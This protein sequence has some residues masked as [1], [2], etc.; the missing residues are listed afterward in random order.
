MGGTSSSFDASSTL[1]S[2]IDVAVKSA[3][4]VSVSSIGTSR[5][6]T[7]PVILNT[8]ALSTAPASAV[9]RSQRFAE[10]A[11]TSTCATSPGR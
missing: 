4:G 5:S 7:S 6:M 3:F 11:V 9:K 8:R 10:R 1:P 2:R